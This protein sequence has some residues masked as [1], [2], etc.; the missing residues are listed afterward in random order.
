MTLSPVAKAGILVTVGLIFAAAGL[1]SYVLFPNILKWQIEKKLTL[2]EESEVFEQWREPSLP[3]YFEVYFFNITNPDDIEDNI[4]KPIIEE[5]GPFSFREKRTK[6][7]ITW[8]EN[9][10][11]SYRLVKSWYFQPDRTNGSLDDNIITVNVP[12]ISAAVG[13]RRMN[14]TFIY[15]LMSELF[16]HTNS[17]LFISRTP[18]QLLFDGYNDTVLA[19]MKEMFPE[20]VPYGQFAW[21][22]KK[23]ESDGNVTFNIFTGEKGIQNYG[24]VDKW[25]GNSNISAWDS[26]CNQIDGSMGEMWPPF[27]KSRY[28]KL[29][30]FIPDICRTVSLSYISDEEM[31]GIEAYRYI[32]DHTI[33]DNGKYDPTNRC[34]CNKDCLPAGGLDVS[35]CQKG[36]PIVMSAPHFLYSDVSY[37]QPIIGLKPDPQRH[38]FYIDLQPQMGIPVNVRAKMQINVILERI[39]GIMQF[40]NITG[41]TYFPVLWFSQSATINEPIV[42][43][44]QLVTQDLPHYVNVGSFLLVVVGGIILMLAIIFSI[45]FIRKKKENKGIY[46]AVKIIKS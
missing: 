34:F 37:T 33:F 43:Q 32:L 27:R 3:I 17:T 25:N 18:R 36:A 24:F 21:F 10:T 26:P 7:N 1:L 42:K 28:E 45:Q 44:L 35:L 9:G 12:M 14:H 30:L 2:S 15:T 19:V 20:L 38:Q 13:A 29:D 39:E 8:H 16:H 5:V 31:Q 40:E 22:Y 46:K 23:N 11:V 6:E 4:S 41:R